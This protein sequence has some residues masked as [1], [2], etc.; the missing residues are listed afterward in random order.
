MPVER[1][2]FL[3]SRLFAI[4]GTIAALAFLFDFLQ[5]P[6]WAALFAVVS[7]V[8]LLIDLPEARRL[9]HLCKDLSPEILAPVDAAAIKPKRNAV[10]VPGICVRYVCQENL[11]GHG[12]LLLSMKSSRQ[13]LI[14]LHPLS[15]R[16][17]GQWEDTITT[18]EIETVLP[19]TR[20]K[21][22]VKN[23]CLSILI[24]QTKN[25]HQPGDLI[26]DRQEILSATPV[27]M[28]VHYPYMQAET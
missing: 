12:T 24:A 23:G 10:H 5:I 26:S 13:G 6:F 17:K 9:H 7:A 3:I 4:L 22:V 28:A 16:S 19:L 15:R 18:Q 25:A 14:C 1:G 20:W 27:T 2:K 8:M 21:D 11:K